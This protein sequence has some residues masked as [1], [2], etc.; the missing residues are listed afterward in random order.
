MIKF[1]NKC[2]RDKEFG[3]DRRNPTGYLYT[4]KDCRKLDRQINRNKDP[5]FYKKEYV[6]NKESYLK[7][8]DK[9]ATRRNRRNLFLVKKYGITLL[10]YENLL[11]E[12]N[13]LCKICKTSETSKKKMG[14]AVDHC[15]ETGKVRG[16]LCNRCN[17]ALGLFVDNVEILTEAVNYLEKGRK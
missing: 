4:C 2:K 13:F 8:Y 14:L 7:Y 16:L 9:D 5:N 6:N 15:H 12:Q 17:R 1:C 11:N 10:D 3:R